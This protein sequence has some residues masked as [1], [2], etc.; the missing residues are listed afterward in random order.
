MTKGQKREVA[1]YLRMHNQL[2]AGVRQAELTLG[3][4]RRRVQRDFVRL[5]AAMTA[6]IAG[7]LIATSAAGA[8]FEQSMAN[9][10]SV[11]RATAAEMAALEERALSLG[12]S[13]AFTASQ[14]AD[15]MY[16]LASGGMNTAQIIASTEGVLK[17]AGAT[18]SDMGMAAEITMATLRQFGIAAEDTSRVVNVFGAGI[19][20]SM[21]NLER[22]GM[23]MAY[24][25]PLANI[26]NVDLETTVGTLA[27]LHNAGVLA[28]RA[29]TG[30]ASGLR[31]LAAPGKELKAVLGGLTVEKDG[32]PAVAQALK[33]AE[34]SAADMARMFE[35]ESIPAVAALANAG[36]DEL[37]KLI[38]AV[39]GTNAAFDMYAIQMNTT[40][41][42]WKQISSA[43]EGT[44]LRAFRSIKPVLND[45]QRAVL[46]WV[47]RSRDGI[48]RTVQ[49]AVAALLRFLETGAKFTRW[50]VEN[51]DLLLDI[52]KAVGAATAAVYALSVAVGV[53]NAAMSAN[54]VGIVIALVAALAAGIVFLVERMGG[55]KIAWV[56]AKRVFAINVEYMKWAWAAVV[57]DFKNFS[58]TADAL[59]RTFSIL[60]T[61]LKDGF[62]VFRSRFSAS[63]GTLWSV[64]QDPRKIG[65]LTTMGDV[66]EGFGRDLSAALG[67][68]VQ[69]EIAM[70]W[71]IAAD[72]S[73]IES[74][75]VWREYLARANQIQ[76]HYK[77]QVAAIRA[78]SETARPSAANYGDDDH[79]N[80]EFIPTVKDDVG[81]ATEALGPFLTEM[82][83]VTLASEN[84]ARA[85]RQGFTAVDDAARQLAG[86]VGGILVDSIFEARDA[87]EALGS[88]GKSVLGTLLGGLINFGLGSIGPSGGFFDRVFGG[89]SALGGYAFAGNVY[90]VNERDQ[91][92]FIP[93][94]NGRIVPIGQMQGQGAG[95]K[96]GG[97]VHIHA[98]ATVVT[99]RGSLILADD[100]QAV[101][102]LAKRVSDEISSKVS[103]TYRE[104]SR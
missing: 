97:D 13:T 95:Q 78:E 45:A 28:E 76:D 24:V 100:N 35:A 5:G 52:A 2:G 59:K 72:H 16:S 92:Y 41:G 96:A 29:G 67:D 1:I 70:A 75:S 14:V 68:G 84:A 25:A 80:F 91:E 38:D 101:A 34:L 83:R 22:L 64:I 4:F 69:S 10:G 89:N 33:D 49:D 54:P 66:W 18:M 73:A 53:V 8:D 21:L 20:N 15:S 62:E 19:Q 93:A 48:V 17:L 58:H 104:V 9:V 60:W 12:E 40:K 39:T 63:W 102:R 47:N 42:L 71:Q 23:S 27:A 11:A 46:E 85:G 26:M 37:Q 30:L 61:S 90:G 87:M 55:W 3:G 56:E 32:L 81:E 31:R 51:A 86:S 98:T 65:L 43:L 36:R 44:M 94:T 99:E 50:V 82:E 57:Q 103:R 88:V 77:A 6:A 74:E 79:L 7:A